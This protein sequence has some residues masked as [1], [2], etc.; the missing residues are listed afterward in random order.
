MHRASLDDIGGVAVVV[1][2]AASDSEFVGLEIGD[3]A[4]I[5]RVP[6]PLAGPYLDASNVFEDTSRG[7]HL[8]QGTVDIPAHWVDRGIVYAVSGHVSVAEDAVLRLDAGV[9]VKIA[10]PTNGILPPVRFHVSGTVE[11]DGTPDEPIIVTSLR[12]DTVAG[13]TNGDARA[14]TPR[15]GLWSAIYVAPSGAA[16]L[17]HT[18]LRYGSGSTHSQVQAG[19]G[20][21]IV[22]GEADVVGLT[23]R[24]PR[25]HGI[26]L[27]TVAPVTLALEDVTIHDTPGA[28]TDLVI[29]GGAGDVTINGLSTRSPLART[30]VLIRRI[31]YTSLTGL[32]LSGARN[33]VEIQEAGPGALAGTIS[34]GAHGVHRSSCGDWE[35]DL[36]FES[37]ATAFVGCQ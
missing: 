14:T 20:A 35:F 34:N 25:G 36:T 13:D 8:T 37:V 16:R 28:F 1:V 26:R 6:A 4:V 2:A 24:E 12:D 18:D 17:R 5:G 32:D 9:V 15:A 27:A 11:F 10:L 29:F 7:L 33:G 3:A 30:G 23:V 22:E 31:G 19:E 21:L